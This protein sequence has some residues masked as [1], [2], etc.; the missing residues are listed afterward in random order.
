M[1]R[2]DQGISSFLSSCIGLLVPVSLPVLPS[3][4]ISLSGFWCCCCWLCTNRFGS[5]NTLSVRPSPCI[6]RDYALL[7]C[8]SAYAICAAAAGPARQG[9]PLSPQT[10]SI[11]QYGEKCS[12][13]GVP[14]GPSSPLCSVCALADIP[15]VCLLPLMG[16]WGIL[17]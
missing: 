3:N 5:K 9:G 8:I 6:R 4:P 17:W 13:F 16:S 2:A 1:R 15:T 7:A 11:L 10:L 12:T 14:T